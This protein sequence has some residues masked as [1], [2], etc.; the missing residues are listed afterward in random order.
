MILIKASKEFW[1]I[2]EQ[3]RPLGSVARECF[4]SMADWLMQMLEGKYKPSIDNQRYIKLDGTHVK[5][6]VKPPWWGVS[7]PETDVTLR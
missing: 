6:S 5:G 4:S 3:Y 1:S 2:K 7:L